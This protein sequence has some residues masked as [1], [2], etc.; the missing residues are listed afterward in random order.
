MKYLVW[1]AESD[2]R[3]ILRLLAHIALNGGL[4]F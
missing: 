4:F 3:E 1:M 2:D